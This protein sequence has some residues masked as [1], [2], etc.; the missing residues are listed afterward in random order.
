MEYDP[1]QLELLMKKVASILGSRLEGLL[2]Q[3]ENIL[4][5]QL[6]Q[7]MIHHK[8][9]IIEEWWRWCPPIRLI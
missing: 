2:K 4:D 5:N 8:Y 7:L 1:E 3:Q 9:D 6:N